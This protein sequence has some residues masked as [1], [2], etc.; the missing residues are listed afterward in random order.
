QKC[1]SCKRSFSETWGTPMAQLNTP[2]SKV[3]GV[4]RVRSEGL[5]LRA[6]GRVFGVHKNTVSTW[7]TKF[8]KQK[9]PLMLY[10]M[11]HQFIS[12][13]FE[14]DELYTIVNKRTEACKS[15]GWTAV[16][17][18]RSSRFIAEQ[19][20]GKRD[21]EMF[22]AIMKVIASYIEQSQDLTFLSDGERRYGNTLFDLCAEQLRNGKRGRPP[23]VL[24]KGVKLRLKNKGSQKSK[25]G[26]KRPKYEAPKREYPDTVQ[27][28]ENADIQA[29]RLEAQNAALRRRNSAFRR[30]TN[31]YAKNTD[32]LQRTLDVHQIIHNFSR[33]HWTTGK[34]PAVAMGIIK[35]ALSL[36]NILTLRVA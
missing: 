22:Q 29:N 18:E 2:L 23:K 34:V 14:G 13:T 5:A 35:E 6:T 31:T 30:R 32:A 10:A 1:L 28:L 20:C 26:R 27:N 8:S 9:K 33:A 17:M 21:Q 25:P 24:P 19:R 3:A 4:I 15:E 12:L 11:C 16:I 7:E 36:E